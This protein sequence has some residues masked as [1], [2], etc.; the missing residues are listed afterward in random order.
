M[1]CTRNFWRKKKGLS[2]KL[3]HPCWGL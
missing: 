3:Q 2:P 1:L